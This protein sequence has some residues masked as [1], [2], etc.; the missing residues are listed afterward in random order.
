MIVANPVGRPTKKNDAVVRVIL[1]QLRR[2]PIEKH[3]CNIAKID[4]D[5]LKAW[6]DCDPNFSL[7]VESAK[8]IG[9]QDLIDKLGEKDPHKVLLA[10]D[11]N[12]WKQRTENQQEVKV[13]IL[14]KEL[15][16]ELTEQQLIEL[17]QNELK[18]LEGNVLDSPVKSE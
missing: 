16:G 7:E 13:L 11:Y 12:T 5:T 18:L 4:Q 14:K 3:A 6:K 2:R 8:A 9:Q 10:S 15:M 1:E 17:T